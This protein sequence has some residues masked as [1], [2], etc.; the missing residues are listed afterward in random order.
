MGCLKHSVLGP[1]PSSTAS[2]FEAYRMAGCRFGGFRW[3]PAVISMILK[4]S[5]RSGE[6]VLK[7]DLSLMLRRTC[8]VGSFDPRRFQISWR[9]MALES[10]EVPFD[11]VS[12]GPVTLRMASSTR[13][14]SAFSEWRDQIRRRVY[15]P[16]GKGLLVS[17]Y[18]S[19][20]AS[21]PVR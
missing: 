21:Q 13:I 10:A 12:V 6:H 7:I 16:N 11:V 1:S 4:R 19:G 17:V 5:L 14:N 8:R 2:S 3:R 20:C 9:A 15:E 18:P